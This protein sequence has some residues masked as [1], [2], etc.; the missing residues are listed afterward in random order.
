MNGRIAGLHGNI[1]KFLFPKIFYLQKSFF[2]QRLFPENCFF[3]CQ[4]QTMEVP[5]SKN[6]IVTS[7][8]A[9]IIIFR[10]KAMQFSDPLEIVF[11]MKIHLCEA[12]TESGMTQIV[13]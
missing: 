9:G 12:Q 4:L 7:A 8:P 6:G 11:L 2:R 5:A 13:R 1:A 3:F 10:D